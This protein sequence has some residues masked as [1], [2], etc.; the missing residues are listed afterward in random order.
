M[1]RRARC[2][3]Q[4]SLAD[5]ANAFRLPNDAGGGDGDRMLLG[6]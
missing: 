5:N 2:V 3:T 4:R 1:T 6:L